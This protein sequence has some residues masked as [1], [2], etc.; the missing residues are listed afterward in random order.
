ML[1]LFLY[2]LGNMFY[3]CFYFSWE[4]GVGGGGGNFKI[5]KKLN[6]ILMI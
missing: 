5:Y 2:K 6:L 1:D 3:R 4:W